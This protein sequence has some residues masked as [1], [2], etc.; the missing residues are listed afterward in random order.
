MTSP[1]E[2]DQVHGLAVNPGNG[3]LYAATHNGVLRL[4]D[5]DGPQRVGEARQDTM[6]FAVAGSDHF[7]ASGHPATG[8]DGPV[9]LGLIEST[10][11]GRTWKTLSLSGGADFHTLRYGHGTV[12]GFNSTNGQL[13]ASKDKTTWDKRADIAL[14]D[15]VI[16]PTDPDMLLATT[17]DGMARSA[18]GG[19]TWTPAAGPQ[20]ALLSWPSSSVLW[21]VT[22]GG[23]VMRSS[24]GGS[25][26]KPTGR[27]EGTPTAFAAH[28]ADLFVAVQEGGVLRSSDAGATWTPAYPSP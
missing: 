1:V 22:A 12:F 27:V 14:R 15:F 24:D 8:Q 9:D 4:P 16:S 28:D 3:S 21:A 18:D 2:I 17:L 23:D 26:W 5:S 13:L 10:D 19:R 11:G 25:G 20:L 6:A 7:L